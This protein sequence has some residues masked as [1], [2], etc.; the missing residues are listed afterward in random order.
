MVV[1]VFKQVCDRKRLEG[2]YDRCLQN[3]MNIVSQSVSI[4]L[5]C[6]DKLSIF[7]VKTSFS[8]NDLTPH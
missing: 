1:N 5:C 6:S 4:A 8:R 3:I 7:C 2:A